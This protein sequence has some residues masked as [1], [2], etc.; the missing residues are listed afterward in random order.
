[1]KALIL[2]DALA[3]GG[4]ETKSVRIVN[5]LVTRGRSIHLAYLKGPAILLPKIDE[6]VPT[7]CLDRK[8][9]FSFTALRNLRDFIE[10]HDISVVMCMNLYPLLYAALLKLFSRHR[11]LKVILA[12]N[13]TDFERKRDRWFMLIYAPLIRRIDAVIYGCK[14]QMNSWQRNYRLQGIRSEVIYNGV[15]S[16]FF[17]PA[18]SPGDLRQELGIESSFVIGCVG[19]L[20]PEKNQSA[21]LK[22]V[23]RLNCEAQRSDV[24]L[25]GTGPE[26]ER[27]EKLSQDL[28]IKERVHFLGRMDDVRKALATMDVFVLPSVSVETF[29]NAALEAMAMSLPV[30]LSDVAGASEMIRDSDDGFLYERYDTAKL[31]NLLERLRIDPELGRRIGRKAGNR[32][33]SQFGILQMFDNYEALLSEV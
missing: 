20:D 7:A 19:R 21:L 14:H 32:A 24:V 9:K 16:D 4:S 13:T 8:G 28:G 11:S 3:V 1:M 10:R 2:L 15:D 22:V 27:L 18:M 5:E 29:S 30:I 25:V 17:D 33:R 6:R 31:G 12:I 23:A 26:R